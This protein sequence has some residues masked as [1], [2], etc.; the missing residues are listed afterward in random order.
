MRSLILPDGVK[1]SNLDLP[2]DCHV[3]HIDS[4]VFDICN[5]LAEVSP[6]LWVLAVFDRPGTDFIIMEDCEDG[7]QRSAFRVGPHWDITA[8]D[9]RVVE[10][11]RVLQSLPL[12]VRVAAIDKEMQKRADQKKEDEL[13][14]LYERMGAPMWGELE[15]CGFIQRPV[16][17]AKR[18]AVG[19][20]GSLAKST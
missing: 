20:K 3:K 11:C 15:R 9:N 5:R 13:D 10:K 17:Y 14:D 7:V 19:G 4:D 12:S 8:L 1:P 2:L 18:G 16:S 6:R